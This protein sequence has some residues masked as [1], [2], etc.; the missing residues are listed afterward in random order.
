MF[1]RL[2]EKR[3]RI[4]L[5]LPSIRQRRWFSPVE[6][7]MYETVTPLIREHFR[8][9]VLDVGAGEMAYAEFVNEVA[10]CYHGIDREMR[11]PG[12]TFVGD[13]ADMH[14]IADESYDC[15]LCLDV[16]EHVPDPKRVILEIRRVC[17]PGG[18]LVLSVPFLHRVHAE[19]DDYWRFTEFGL[20]EILREGFDVVS[21][22]DRGGLCCFLGNQVSVLWMTVFFGTFLYRPVAFFNA[23]FIRACFWLDAKTRS[24]TQFATGHTLLARRR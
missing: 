3:S 20:R 15:I 17:K 7:G 21:A 5:A 24:G 6:H 18:T 22:R 9:R 19:P 14:M 12:L 16:L 8:G 10:D 4:S 2:M 23:L 1:A 13:V 11:T